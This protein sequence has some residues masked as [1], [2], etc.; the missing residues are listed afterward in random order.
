MFYVPG[1]FAALV[2]SAGAYYLLGSRAAQ[3][4]SVLE[5]QSDNR[6][7]VFFRRSNGLMMLLLGIGLFAGV[8]AVDSNHPTKAFFLI[9]MCDCVLLLVIVSLV[10]I[11]LRLTMKMRESRREQRAS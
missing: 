10:L 5:S 11:D 4:L 6:R 3:N 7:R 1:I 8:Y 2:T 9:W